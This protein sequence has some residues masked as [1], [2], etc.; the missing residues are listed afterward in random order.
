[1]YE[2]EKKKIY[3]RTPSDAWDKWQ[4]FFESNDIVSLCCSFYSL[5]NCCDIGDRYCSF[6]WCLSL[7][8]CY[9]VVLIDFMRN[10][11]DNVKIYYNNN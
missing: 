1:M 8:Y 11:N 10:A 3:V 7:Y 5:A 9:V 4:Y 6:D 2:V